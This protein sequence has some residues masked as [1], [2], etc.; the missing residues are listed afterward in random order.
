MRGRG[1]EVERGR[2]EGEEWSV[3]SLFRR[4]EP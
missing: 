4:T 1:T 2:E 3:N